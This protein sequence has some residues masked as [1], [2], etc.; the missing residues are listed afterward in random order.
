MDKERII[1]LIKEL[2][3]KSIAINPREEQVIDLVK[4]KLIKQIE[5]EK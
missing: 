4:E 5:E 2:K 1:K 3:P